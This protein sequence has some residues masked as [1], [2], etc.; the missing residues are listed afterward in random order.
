MKT[1]PERWTARTPIEDMDDD[2][3]RAGLLLR[4]S[5]VRQPLSAGALA[6]IQ[7]R[8]AD[9]RH[10]P[11]RRLVLS[12]GVA[13]AIFLSGGAL[14]MS[15]T[16]FGHWSPFHRSPARPA[17]AAAAP[18]RQRAHAASTTTA[19][20]SAEA[21]VE[22]APLGA[23]PT[24]EPRRRWRAPRLAEPVAPEVLPPAEPAR[25]SAIA[26][27]AA[28]LGA[29]LRALREG[30][31]APGALALLDA[32]DAR[33]GATG[34]L[35]DEASTTRVEALLRLGRH[36]R[37]LALLDEQSPRP[38]GRGRELLVSRGELRAD[39]GRC[40]EAVT[41]FDAL[42]ADDAAADGAAE[43]ALYGRAACRART[44]DAA[45]ARADL[46]TYLAR[47]PDGRFAS[48]V[49]AALDR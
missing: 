24:P 40:A 10:S 41:D 42:L 36:T 32:H 22:L 23:T 13:L 1:P 30:D 44:V 5:V 47:Y 17:P 7:M 27:E 48:R 43:R 19:S 49:R 12:L 16:L 29:A 14:V 6:D 20:T 2:E 18:A 3:A 33:F 8:L 45:A 9:E 25:T 28:L 4:R 15:A 46:E 37:A 31:D 39:A 38:V 11:A 34:A 35:G 21:V 26:E